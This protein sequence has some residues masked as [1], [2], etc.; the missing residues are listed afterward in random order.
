[1]KVA[2]YGV[3]ASGKDHLIGEIVAYLSERGIRMTHVRGSTVLE[4]LSVERYGCGFSSLDED[5]KDTL[6]VAFADALGEREGEFGNVIVDGHFAFP[7]ADGAYRDV[8]TDSDLMAYDLF[9][10]LDTDP[11]VVAGRL[12]G[13][14]VRISPEDVG[15]WQDHEVNGLVSRLLPSGKELHVIRDDGEPTLR[16]ILES[17]GGGWSSEVIA[18]RAVGALADIDVPG[19]VCLVDC[20]R[21]LV[22]E[23]STSLALGFQSKD[24]SALADIYARDRYSNYQSFMASEWLDA[25]LAI[26]D[27]TIA[28]VCG[29]ATPNSGLVASL[30]HAP[31]TQVVAIT[32]GPAEIW[33]PLLDSMG[34]AAELLDTGGVMSKHVKYFAV[35]ELQRL[36]HFVVAVGD[37]MLDSLMLAQADRAYAYAGKGRRES[38]ARFLEANPQVRQFSFSAYQYPGIPSDGAI[39][40]VDCLDQRDPAIAAEVAVCKSGSGTVGR[41]LRDAHRRLGSMV[42]RRIATCNRGEEFAVVV[43]M[44]S[45]LPFGE[46]IADTLDCPMLFYA[47]DAEALASEIAADGLG[48]R[49][50]IL[51]D[52][53]INTGRSLRELVDVLKNL[54]L[55]VAASVVS[56]EARLRPDTQVFSAR[57]SD[58]SYVGAKQWEISGGRG[59]DTA[60][61]LFMTM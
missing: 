1:M 29:S 14:G 7:T 10:Y 5:D 24:G 25:N 46:G 56:S 21:T 23:D 16:Y 3:S 4:R 42:G 41:R 18:R 38:M 19:V 12:A 49:T 44:R 2:V 48:E 15:R 22:E 39:C 33:S 61:R 58:N 47:D 6:R 53:V 9:V 13:R 40:W 11:D 55:V 51:A 31:G 50:I 57:V 26:D 45:G 20:D 30:A 17:I 27:G 37:S 52:G 36:G 35:R 59:P 60:D 43:M 54:R 28:S 34:V 32:A 8:F